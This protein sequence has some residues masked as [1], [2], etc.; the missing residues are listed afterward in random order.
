LLNI[1]FPQ[2]PFAGWC[3]YPLI[4]MVLIGGML[5]FLAISSRARET[6]ERKFFI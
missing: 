6:M 5:I 1:T 2:L 4:A 3:W